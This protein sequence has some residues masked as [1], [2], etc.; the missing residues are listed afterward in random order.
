MNDLQKI[1]KL[2]S[3]PSLQ[4]LAS[5]FSSTD[6]EYKLLVEAN[7]LYASIDSEIIVIHKF[8]RDHYSTRYPE[9]ETMITGPTEYAKAVAIIGNGPFDNVKELASKSD[10][11]LGQPLQDALDKQTLMIVTTEAVRSQGRELSDSQ[12]AIVLRGC[13]E[14][15]Y[16]DKSRA[17][18]SEYVQSR[19][20]MFAPNLTALLGSITAAQL[21]NSAGGLDGLALKPN[22]N[23]ASIGSKK[24]TQAGF[25][26]NVGVKQ[27]GFLYYSELFRDVSDDYMK[28]A[29]RV[30]SGKATLAARIDLARQ[31]R[32]GLKGEDFK[33]ECLDK[34]DKITGPPLNRGPKALPAPDDKPS[35]KRGGRKVRKMKEATAQTDLQK[36]RNRLAFGKEEAE[37]GYGTGEGTIGMGMLGQDND[38]RIRALKIDQRTRA[39]LSKKNQGWGAAT[40]LSGTASSLRGFGQG[41]GNA[42]VLRGYGIRSTGIGGPSA[43]TA[44]SIAFTPV[45]GLELV[46]PLAQKELKR[47]REVEEDK[48]FKGGTFTQVGSASTAATNGG[49]KVPALPAK[50][51]G[52]MGPPPVPKKTG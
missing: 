52:N 17:A 31:Y 7:S 24:Q 4:S 42:S 11:I 39:K 6:P 8:I 3:T 32:D 46:N 28:Q 23:L 36:A 2:D 30:V 13:E 35:R 34:L 43:G 49:F 22:C 15:F 44:S 40:P 50:T 12:L 48:W 29:M 47:K 33:S 10:N 51:G 45:Q 14:V 9:L 21:V 16:L 41:N 26:R 37:A 20:S 19:M 27:K 18:L 5:R 1:S 25:A 38:G